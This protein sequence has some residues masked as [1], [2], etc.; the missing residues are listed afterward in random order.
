M[1]KSHCEQSSAAQVFA[2]ISEGVRGFDID[3]AADSIEYQA[4]DPVL[5]NGLWLRW[6]I[7][8][9]R[10]MIPWLREMNT[11]SVHL[12]KFHAPV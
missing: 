6:W 10:A 3:R 8:T 11:P 1:L 12:C 4:R 7:R 9:D 2:F 5:K